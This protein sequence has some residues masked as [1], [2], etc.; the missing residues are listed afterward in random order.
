[1]G[2]T[3]TEARRMNGVC[4]F[5]MMPS[6]DRDFRQAAARTGIS[7]SA[8]ANLLVCEFVNRK[9]IVLPGGRIDRECKQNKEL[10]LMFGRVIGCALG[11]KVQ[12]PR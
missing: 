4:T 8:L 3:G 1:M 2:S 10:D 11:E 6:T 5:R 7:P 9:L 12:M